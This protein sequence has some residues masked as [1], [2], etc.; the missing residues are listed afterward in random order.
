MSAEFIYTNLLLYAF[1]Q[2]NPAKRPWFSCTRLW[3][4][5][6]HDLARPRFPAIQKPGE[7]KRRVAGNLP[8]L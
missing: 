8:A 5:E 3:L 2:D 1:S 6:T 4:L 7:S